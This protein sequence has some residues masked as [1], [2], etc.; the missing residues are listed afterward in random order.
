M[1]LVSYEYRGTAGA[2]VLRGEEV[3]STGYGTM[4]E[5]IQTGGPHAERAGA[6][7]IPLS[8]CRI[9]AP[10]PTPSKVLFSGL[11]YRSHLEENPSATLP[12]YPQ[13]FAK[14][15]SSIIGPGEAIVIPERHSQVDYEVE[16]A[17]V[18]GKRARGVSVEQ[19]LDHVFGY[20]VVNDVSGRD[21]QFR[22]NQITTGKGFDT[23]CPMGPV[24][25]TREAIPDPQALPLRSF[26][27][28]EARQSGTTADM[29]FSVATLI[30]FLSA[31]ITLLP[32]DV[33]ATGTPAG[34]GCFR[35]P[36]AYL[37]PGD[38]VS[39]E[40]VG[41]GRLTNPVVAGW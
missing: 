16:L 26:V 27:N 33:I 30:A 17:L 9:L 41:I 3:V 34:V 23:F 38:E 21:V 40:V 25:V 4:L 8:E 36:P 29:L 19:A 39:V 18:I 24:L 15:P 37:Q 20:T 13:I 2:G 10:M 12:S 35:K 28:G 11:N 32:G 5:L 7:P 14:L 22:D 31:H 6:A 1:Q